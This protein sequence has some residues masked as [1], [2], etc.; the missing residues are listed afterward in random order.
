MGHRGRPVAQPLD[1]GFG[2]VAVGQ[3]QHDLGARGV[4]VEGDQRRGVAGPDDQVALPVAELGAVGDRGGTV[5]DGRECAQEVRRCL[6]SPVAAAAAGVAAGAQ[7]VAGLDAQHAA[8]HAL[9]DR[10]GAHPAQQVGGA[11]RE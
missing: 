7:H 11:R 1:G 5:V 10:L 6:G 3:V 4:L 2:A 9:V 8:V